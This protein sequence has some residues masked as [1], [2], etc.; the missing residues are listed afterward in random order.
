[1]SDAILI[2]PTCVPY[3]E[4]ALHESATLIRQ[5]SSA[6]HIDI[7][8]GIFTQSLTWPYSQPGLREKIDLS[9]LS[10]MRTY[11]H[12]M[13]REPRDLGIECAQAGAAFVIGH[14]EAFADSAT[15]NEALDEWHEAGALT[16]LAIL[17]DTPL[18]TLDPII[19][20]CDLVLVMSSMQIGEQGAPF[21]S[22]TIDRVRELSARYPALTIGIDIG[23]SD[24]TIGELVGAGATIF[25][26][27][28]AI[29]KSSDPSEAYR[30]LKNL[31]ENALQ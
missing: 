19:S 30:Q 14:I 9:R 18:A 8:D 1:M 13:V 15:A 27:G 22:R 4:D 7:D 10:D 23:V 3:T 24:K 28:S 16:G 6:I 25:S 21:E 26:V 17:N 12:L 11:M 5:F 31:A 20:A 29:M 2:V